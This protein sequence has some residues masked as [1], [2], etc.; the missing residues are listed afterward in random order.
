M[1]IRKSSRV[2]DMN[3]KYKLKLQN[4]PSKSYPSS[5]TPQDEVIEYRDHILIFMWNMKDLNYQS[6]TLIN[7]ETK[8][9][10]IRTKEWLKENHPEYLI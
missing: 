10:F 1:A 6:I 2:H 7:N 8:K 9:S 5:L 3:Y 4:Y